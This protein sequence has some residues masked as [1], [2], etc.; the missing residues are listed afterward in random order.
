MLNPT[1]TA[2]R[3]S[4][5]ATHTLAV[6]AELTPPASAAPLIAP[7]IAPRR[8]FVH[9]RPTGPVDD[10]YHWL[11]D[12]DDPDTIAYL[13]AENTYADAWFAPHGDLVETIFGEIKS[14]IQE[15][16]QSVPTFKDGWW[17][18]TRTEE[19]A[20]YAIHCRGSS[21]DTAT[22]D[23][24][25]DENVEA[26]GHE[27]FSVGAFDVSPSSQLLAWSLD[28]DGSEHFTMH[29]RDLSTG[30]DLTDE[31]HDTSWA[32]TAWSADS[33]F[34]FY[35][36][37][38][39]QERPSTVWRHEIGT[40][41]SADVQVF[42]EPDERFY[43][44]ID[45]TRSGEWIVIDSDSKTSSETWLIPAS[46]PLDS[47][48]LVRPREAD[49]EYHLDHWG[50]RFVIL[51]NLD[52]IDFR[53]MTA[54][55][56]TPA[57][58]TEFLP[59]VAGN[60][61]MRVDPFADHLVVH[62]WVEAQPRLRIVHRAGRIDV[63][64]LGDAPHD[65]DLAANPE[66]TTE[67][68]RFVTE[69]MVSPATVWEHNVRTGERN[70][71]KRAPT[72]NVDLDRYASERY[73]ATSA[74]G[75]KVPYD[76][77]RLA[78]SPS[79]TAGPAVVYAYGSYEASMPPWFS[80]ARLSLVDR[81]WT[82]VLAHPRGGGEMGRRWYLEGKLLNKRNT[83]DDTNAVADDLVA[84]GLADSSRLAVRGGSAGGLLVG[85]CISL[86]PDR[87]ASAVAEV[88]FVDV[89]STMS[90][91]SLPLTV[92]EW[93]EWG[94]PRSEPFASY[95]ASY[96]PYDITSERAYPAL[97]VTAGLNDPRVSYHE[98]AKWVALIRAIRT[99]EAPLVLR[100]EMGAG[101]GGQSGRYEQWRDEARVCAFLQATIG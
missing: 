85:A 21:R 25:L 19:G 93:E 38:D 101:H 5:C 36:T 27:Y 40:V 46:S 24:L 91:P 87:W 9:D 6:M 84:R 64:D 50:D 39:E 37:Y 1:G 18:A 35:V 23:V 8:P 53:V 34:L 99:N 98:P 78:T 62:E 63:L 48:S 81:G 57:E 20:Q 96:S 90:D 13:T 52:A 43:V 75:T 15:T 12:K 74:D 76:V 33:R 60:R 71:L 58:W 69:S 7:P 29:V 70:L 89:V 100:T 32:G 4:S 55:V 92:T 42:H 80:V 47:P 26:E 49:L 2:R 65:V 95:I 14:R 16:D 94:D 59:H 83:F 30:S 11:R 82:W 22:A 77:V 86:R 88:P 3:R 61:I 97:F 31:I 17:Y 45:L 66:W 10:P 28:I 54:P 44:G 41:Q 67:W 68:L 72:P 56:A 73:W 51:T 79:K